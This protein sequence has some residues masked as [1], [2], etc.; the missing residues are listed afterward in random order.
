MHAPK[1]KPPT[2]RAAMA[3]AKAQAYQDAADAP[4]TLR[5]YQRISNIY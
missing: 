2:A 1:T 5:A 3:M 4:A